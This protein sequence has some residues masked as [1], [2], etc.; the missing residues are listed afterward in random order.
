[1]AEELKF[2]IHRALCKATVENTRL[3]A[4]H[5]KI[6]EEELKDKSESLDHQ[7]NH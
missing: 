3:V 1:M 5:L 4:K 2:T 7:Q 6:T